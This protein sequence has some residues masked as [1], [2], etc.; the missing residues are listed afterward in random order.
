MDE[1]KQ[2]MKALIE[3]AKGHKVRRDMA[4][5]EYKHSMKK[6]ELL[7]EEYPELAREYGIVDEKKSE[8]KGDPAVTI[9]T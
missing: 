6:L 2:Q 4:A 3:E 8:K 5:M 7:A 9:S 1:I